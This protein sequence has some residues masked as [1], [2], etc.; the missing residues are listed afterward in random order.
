VGSKLRLTLE[1]GPLLAADTFRVT[2]TRTRVNHRVVSQ[3]YLLDS[4]TGYLQLD[5]FTSLAPKE[6]F[7]A[8]RKARD[9]GARQLVLDLRGNSGGDIGAMSEIASAFL[10]GNLEVF[11]TEGRRR[12]FPAV[13]TSEDGDFVKL[14]LVLLIDAQSAS[15]AEILAGSLQDHDRAVVVGRRSF[16]KALIQSSMPLPNGDVV[17][18]TTARV[19][20]PSGRIIQ[21]RYSGGELESYLERAGTEGPPDDTAA[22]YR[23]ARGREVKGG[24][25][26]LPDIV[27]PAPVELP[28]WFTVALDS[29][30][31]AVVDSAARALGEGA[32][33]RSAWMA[34]SLAWDTLLVAPFVS[35]LQT[36]LAQVAS[37]P[38][39]RSR[40]RRIFASRAAGQRWGPE[41]ETEFQVRN[42]E[43]IHAALGAFSRLPALLR[44]TNPR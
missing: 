27:R 18:L 4:R 28:V 14:P 39:L 3:P 21:R 44:Q 7:A 32:R 20:T 37:D 25:G 40:I 26:I 19:V 43:D 38:P 17:W 5:E 42:D 41:A 15:A 12:P 9:L 11:S 31:G 10:P 35:R 29:G 13:V 2:L 23:T 36:R 6:L 8:I 34:D 22:I 24:G 30:Y 16:G 33:A 1:R